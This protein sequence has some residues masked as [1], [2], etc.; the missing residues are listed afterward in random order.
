M[1]PSSG[2]GV[3]PVR[4]KWET[5]AFAKERGGGA[6][7][8]SGGA[9]GPKSAKKSAAEGA[10]AGARLLAAKKSASEGAGAE[11]AKSRLLRVDGGRP[12][13]QQRAPGM[14]AAA[15][16]HTKWEGP[17]ADAAVACSPNENEAK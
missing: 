5:G 4:A 2:A 12:A 14:R 3:A 7:T 15:H 6:A 16:V 13:Q 8:G 10:C 17:G 11:D 1:S 9:A